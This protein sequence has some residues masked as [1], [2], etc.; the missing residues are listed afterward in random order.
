MSRGLKWEN[1]LPKLKRKIYNARQQPLF[2]LLNRVLI[3]VVVRRGLI[4]L[5]NKNSRKNLW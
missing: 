1:K 4:T 5:S 2:S 3:A